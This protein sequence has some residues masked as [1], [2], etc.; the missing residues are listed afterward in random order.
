[1]TVPST[2]YCD[3][4]FL[5]SNYAISIAKKMLNSTHAG[6]TISKTNHTRNTQTIHCK[7]SVP[8]KTNVMRTNLVTIDADNK[9]TFTTCPVEVEQC[10]FTYITHFPNALNYPLPGNGFLCNLKNPSDNSK[11]LKCSRYRHFVHSHNRP[12]DI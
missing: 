6:L 10:G 9:S 12:S 2:S 4:H 1:M 7:T 8:Q 11:S 5:M 3:F